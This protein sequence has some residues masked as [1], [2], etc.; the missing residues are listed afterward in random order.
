MSRKNK[1]NQKE[2]F[3]IDTRYNSRVVAKFANRMMY[4]GK[5]YNKREH[6]L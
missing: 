2:N 1:K 4:D 6:T 3:T 5:K